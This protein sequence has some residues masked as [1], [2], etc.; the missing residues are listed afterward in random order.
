MGSFT[1][2]ELQS[3]FFG[4]NP[5]KFRVVCPQIGT[6]VLKGLTQYRRDAIQLYAYN[7][8]SQLTATSTAVAIYTNNLGRVLVRY[9]VPGMKYLV[10]F[11][12]SERVVKK[13]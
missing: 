12:L 3:H 7:R 1:L 9:L 5:L 2:L 4:D 8:V 10:V 11:Q 13:K 6:A